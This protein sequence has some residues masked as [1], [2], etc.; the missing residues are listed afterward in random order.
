MSIRAATPRLSLLRAIYDGTTDL[1]ALRL[2]GFKVQTINSAAVSRQ[3]T[4]ST[5]GEVL[6]TDEGKQYLGVK[7]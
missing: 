4:V 2:H 6:L 1:D 5:D 3:L 7:R